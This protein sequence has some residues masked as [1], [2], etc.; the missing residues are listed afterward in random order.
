MVDSENGP[1][2][3]RVL[4]IVTGVRMLGASILFRTD[5]DR[6]E[7]LGARRG[8]MRRMSDVLDRSDLAS[9]RPQPGSTVSCTSTMKG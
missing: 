8:W 3:E 9:R 5:D 6:H 1:G 4:R 2:R 7:P